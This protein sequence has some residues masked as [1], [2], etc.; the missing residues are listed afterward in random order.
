MRLELSGEVTLCKHCLNRE[1]VKS[2]AREKQQ[3]HQAKSCD[4]CG[5][6]LDDLGKMSGEIIQKMSEYEFRTFLVGASIP[7]DIMDREDEF[8]S[9]HK[10]KGR[11]SIKSQITRMISE[12]VVKSSG[13][14]I[15]YS[16]PDLTVLVSLAESG[17]TIDPRSIWL[18]A[19]Y[20]KSKRGVP[21]RSSDCNTCHGLGCAVC[22]Y[23][24]ESRISVQS[25]A[26]S[27]FMAKFQ[28]ESCNFIWLGSEDPNSLVMGSGRPFYVEVTK[29]KK[30]LLERET[31]SSKSR[32][33]SKENTTLTFESDEGVEIFGT[34]RLE[35]R[36]TDIPKFE[37]LC[38]VNLVLREGGSPMPASQ[39]QEILQKF[40]NM[41]VNVRLSRK[42]RTVQ[43]LIRS[44]SLAG[45]T[46]ETGEMIHLLMQ[47]EGGIPVKKFVTGQDNTVEPNLSELVGAYEIDQKQPFDILEIKVRAKGKSE[48]QPRRSRGRGWET[49]R[50]HRQEPSFSEADATTEPGHIEE[51]LIEEA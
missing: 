46:N 5:G 43:R 34:E 16:R 19:A 47:C 30:R 40:S 3:K 12:Q 35:K 26:G 45:E 9:A 39:I 8:R 41:V 38:R 13:K 18:S 24:G 36:V 50:R 20:R 42:Y 7:Q 21:Q 4:I 1:G 11:E 28:A 33:K 48:G 6:L 2:Q 27:F 29:P 31:S 10:I 15:D 23:M 32:S 22:N 49:K 25:I 37:M 44:I 51:P 17:I 14:Q